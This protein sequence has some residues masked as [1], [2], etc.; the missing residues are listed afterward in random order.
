MEESERRFEGIWW[1]PS[2]PD[3]QWDGILTWQPAKSPRLRLNYRSVGEIVPPDAT[4]AFLGV[5]EGGTP[6]TVLRAGWSGGTSAG[7]LSHRKYT[8]G[9][10]LR[11]IHVESLK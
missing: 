9:H 4:E 1:L 11:G 7:F 2:D 8:A 5:D 10:I 3:S 6:I